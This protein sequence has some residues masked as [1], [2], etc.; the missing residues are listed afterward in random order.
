MLGRG[1]VAG[2]EAQLGIRDGGWRLER[3]HCQLRERQNRILIALVGELPTRPHLSQRTGL[4]HSTFL[5]DVLLSSFQTID[6]TLHRGA[7]FCLSQDA[8]RF[9]A[10]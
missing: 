6:K 9:G 4:V 7:L 1:G 8:F 10:H 2:D 3:G 5:L